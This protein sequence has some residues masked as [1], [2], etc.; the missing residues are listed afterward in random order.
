MC[1]RHFSA[2]VYNTQIYIFGGLQQDGLECN[3][4]VCYERNQENLLLTP[5]DI[6]SK[7]RAVQTHGF[8]ALFISL[9]LFALFTLFDLL[10]D[11]LFVCF[12][13]LHYEIYQ[14]TKKQKQKN[15]VFL[16]LP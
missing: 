1:L 10:F 13:F 8:L 2:V 3:K 12:F 9:D 4:L 14:F 15:K 5:E 11:L 7:W 6:S 16:L